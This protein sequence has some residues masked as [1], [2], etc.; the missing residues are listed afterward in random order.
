MTS[1]KTPLLKV[2]GVIASHIIYV[3]AEQLAKA[4]VVIL[5]KLLGRCSELRDVHCAKADG[6]ILVRVLGKDIK[7][8]EVQFAKASPRIF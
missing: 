1:V 4:S 7:F 2:G 5:I 3:N 8:K 6:A